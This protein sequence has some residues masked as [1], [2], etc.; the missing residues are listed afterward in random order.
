VPL[1]GHNRIRQVSRAA[2]AA[3]PIMP[4]EPEMLTAIIASLR[5]TLNRWGWFY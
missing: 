3:R 5:Q 1:A 2:T 4:P